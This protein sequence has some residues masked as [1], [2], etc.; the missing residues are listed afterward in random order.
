MTVTVYIWKPA[1][2]SSEIAAVF[3]KDVGHV[4]INVKNI[5]ISHRPYTKNENDT[6][7]ELEFFI[8]R[9][10]LLKDLDKDLTKIYV[11]MRSV[12]SCY[13]Y[14]TNY[15]EE[16]KNRSRSADLIYKIHGINENEMINYYHE[17]KKEYHPLNNNCSGIVASMI[18]SSL[19]TKQKEIPLIK[20]MLSNGNKDD[21]T[22]K[23]I[24]NTL[25][26]FTKLTDTFLPFF[27]DGTILPILFRYFFT[28]KGPQKLYDL[29]R[30]NIWTPDRI[31]SLIKSL[32]EIDELRIE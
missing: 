8:Q 10:F 14:S 31:N 21:E 5:Y 7:Y 2:I 16:V 29:W 12:D 4:S 27:Y 18:I 24:F 32:K 30:S 11:P 3:F 13:K 26:I 28:T 1:Q 17:N 20:N 9:E 19:D 22:G 23:L 25:N 6:I 15:D